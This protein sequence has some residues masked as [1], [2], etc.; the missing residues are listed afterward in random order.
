MI[1]FSA[2]VNA[3]FLVLILSHKIK[4]IYLI[5]LISFHLLAYKNNNGFDIYEHGY[6]NYILY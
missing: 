5:F 4:L 6:Y 2:F 3:L 1:T